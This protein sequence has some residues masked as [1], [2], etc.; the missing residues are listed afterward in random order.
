MKMSEVYINGTLSQDR[1]FV[2]IYDILSLLTRQGE[3]H[4]SSP[5]K[6]YH[7]PVHCHQTIRRAISSTCGLVNVQNSSE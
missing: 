5:G 3:A 6:E 2:V 1:G 4:R 7:S